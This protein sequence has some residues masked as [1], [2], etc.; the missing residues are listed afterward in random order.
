M[1]GSGRSLFGW[2]FVLLALTGCGGAATRGGA[3]SSAPSLPPERDPA[4]LLEQGRA[5]QELG[6]ALRAQ[7]YFA[8]SL[9]AGAHEDVAFP[10]LMRACIDQK[11]YRL[12]VEYVEATLARHP[13]DARLRF[14]AGALHGMVGDSARSRE[15]LVRA[16][17]E[18][19]DDAEVQ[20]AVGV[21]FRD[22]VNDVAAADPY[23]RRYLTLAPEGAHAEEA[24][25]STMVEL[26]A[27]EG[28]LS[29]LGDA[30]ARVTLEATEVAR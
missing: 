18:L 16:A 12:A 19:P 1:D 17:K 15:R 28:P 3:S 7:Q 24:K 9:K 10:L 2:V 26:K 27:S 6:D 21:F 25:S 11:N 23:F 4:V 30:P 20:F 8:A 13:R 22:D 29:A 14:L 5:Y